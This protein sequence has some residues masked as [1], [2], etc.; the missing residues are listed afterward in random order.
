MN[1]VEIAQGVGL[2]LK[3]VA[4]TDG[5][6]Y[7]GP[8]P[9]CG[10]K[11]R[12]II[13]PNK[14]KNKCYGGYWCRQCGIHG[15]A[16]QFCREFYGM[17][18]E[19]AARHV[20]ANIEV[21]TAA[22]KFKI[23]SSTKFK[24]VELTNPPARW[25]LRA[26]LLTLF[27]QHEILQNSRI[28]VWL[29]KR[30]ISDEL[31]VKHRLGW[32]PEEI[33]HLREDWGL[34]YEEDE[35]GKPRCVWVPEGLVIPTIDSSSEMV[36][37]MKIRREK[38]IEGDRLPKYVAVSGSMKGLSI[39]GDIKK[40]VILVVESELD[41][42]VLA[43]LVGDIAFSVAVGGSTKNPDYVTDYLARNAK[44]LL[45]GHDNDNAGLEVFKK[46]KNIYSHAQAFPT[47][48]GKDIGEAIALGFDVKQWILDKL[49]DSEK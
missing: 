10:G 37:R 23:V 27:S 42:I 1:L 4:E 12:F 43:H 33:F 9:A 24:P 40:S 49:K 18:F 31:I 17:S 22:S 13:Q 36:I 30:G 38:W 26:D 47:P 32:C 21:I 7:H 20:N 41:A 11:D 2:D 34:A 3:K 5:G 19:E 15:D 44:S 45:I 16:I 48:V 8:C 25:L 35:N 6:E 46:W 29:H 28:R 14:K 39:F